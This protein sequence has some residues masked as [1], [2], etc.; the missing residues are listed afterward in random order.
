MFI[1]GILQSYSI[2]GSKSSSGKR[3]KSGIA[4]QTSSIRVFQPRKTIAIND[5]FFLERPRD[6]LKDGKYEEA[7]QWI[8][9]N[10]ITGTDVELL[11]LQIEFSRLYK[12]EVQRLTREEIPKLVDFLVKLKDL[13]IFSNFSF[14]S[15]ETDALIAKF[16][17]EAFLGD[18]RKA[19]EIYSSLSQLTNDDFSVPESLNIAQSIF[20]FI[21]IIEGDKKASILTDSQEAVMWTS[22]LTKFRRDI[23]RNKNLILEEL[24]K[25]IESLKH[26]LD[27]SEKSLPKIKLEKPDLDYLDR[28]LTKQKAE[29]LKKRIEFLKEKKRYLLLQDLLNKKTLSKMETSFG[30]RNNGGF[31]DNPEN[32]QKKPSS[33][34]IETIES[35]IEESI[36]QLNQLTDTFN[37]SGF[38]SKLSDL[39]RLNQS[40]SPQQREDW[41]FG[42]PW[43]EGENLVV[44][45]ESPVIPL[46]QPIL[47]LAPAE[48]P[49]ELAITP[50]IVSEVTTKDW[51]EEF[52]RA[53]AAFNEPDGPTIIDWRVS[54]WRFWIDVAHWFGKFTQQKNVSNPKIDNSFSSGGDPLVHT[55]QGPIERFNLQTYV[56]QFLRQHGIENPDGKFL[57]NLMRIIYASGSLDPQ[58][59]NAGEGHDL[60]MQQESALKARIEDVLSQML[61]LK[62]VSQPQQSQQLLQSLLP[63]IESTSGHVIEPQSTL[64]PDLD[65][66]PAISSEEVVI[67]V[68][69]QNDKPESSQTTSSVQASNTINQPISQST[70]KPKDQ[71]PDIFKIVA[72]SLSAVA[73][74]VSGFALVQYYNAQNA[75]Q[76]SLASLQNPSGSPSNAAGLTSQQNSSTQSTNS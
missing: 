44:K 58:S 32:S 16:I 2:Q 51:R 45:T 42:D 75:I 38:L 9:D 8:A 35:Q 27:A 43:S 4:K 34:R 22:F 53:R 61:H 39:A 10:G 5:L 57:D 70:Q 68:V 29:E 12:P 24:K 1:S 59:I 50:E 72:G 65:D 26:L 41:L 7:L 56:L 28:V 19:K 15:S 67:D 46:E 60:T 6:L 20:S 47:L 11:R 64:V 76:S 63:T 23:L 21:K 48:E 49:T 55:V 74:G 14:E 62:P 13:S 31:L 69:S 40:L 71:K 36:N 33:S 25:Q 30:R 66:K 3:F 52:P 73:A 37:L 54:L 18:F 17:A